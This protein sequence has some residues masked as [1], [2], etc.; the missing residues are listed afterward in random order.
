MDQELTQAGIVIGTVAYMSPEQA[1][2]MRSAD[3][4]SDIYSLG[5]TLFYLLTGRSLY[6]EETGMKALLAHREQPVPS[7]R[8]FC[9]EAPV[10]LDA[11]FRTMVA[12]VLPIGCNRWTK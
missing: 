8:E 11:V 7:L 5:C 12:N 1:L 2:D 9:E 4:R 6:H 10:S 3:Q